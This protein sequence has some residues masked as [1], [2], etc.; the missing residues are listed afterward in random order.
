MGENRG[1]GYVWPRDDGRVAR[2]G[3]PALCAECAA[4]AAAKADPARGVERPATPGVTLGEDPLSGTPWSRMVIGDDGVLCAWDR[5][6]TFHLW[7]PVEE[8]ADVVFRASSAA[9][10]DARGAFEAGAAWVLDEHPGPGS[11]FAGRRD[12]AYLAWRDGA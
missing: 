1:H 12:A 10:A 9:V 6:G 3:G 2:C 8:V 4:D 7:A 5:D 11:L